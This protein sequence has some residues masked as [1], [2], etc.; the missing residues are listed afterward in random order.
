M[1]RSADQSRNALSQPNGRKPATSALLDNGHY[2]G[3]K[4][5]GK[6]LRAPQ[7]YFEIFASHFPML[8]L[9]APEVVVAWPGTTHRL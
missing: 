4:L 1:N 5:G 8:R 9:G 6:Y 2:A 7:V 3:N